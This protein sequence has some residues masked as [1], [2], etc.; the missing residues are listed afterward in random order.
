M[1]RLLARAATAAALILMTATGSLG[2]GARITFR[3]RGDAELYRLFVAQ[4][5]IDDELGV[6]EIRIHRPKRGDH[7][8]YYFDVHGI[9]PSRGSLFLMV[10]ISDEGHVSAGSNIIELGADGYCDVFDVD[11]N[12]RITSTDALAVARKALGLKANVHVDGS[13]ITALE[14][15]KISATRE[16]V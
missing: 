1:R 6:R 16:C 9:D 11:D 8:A 3:E 7:G 4:P 13:I 12:G 14:I 15:L 2:A 10:S 5:N